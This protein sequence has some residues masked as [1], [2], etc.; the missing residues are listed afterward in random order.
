MQSGRLTM[1]DSG[2]SSFLSGAD[3]IVSLLEVVPPAG[4][5]RWPSAR[6]RVQLKHVE[7]ADD[8]LVAYEVI[9]PSRT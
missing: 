9:D 7:L 6:T 2:N 1:G 8:W 5:R 4:A 3:T